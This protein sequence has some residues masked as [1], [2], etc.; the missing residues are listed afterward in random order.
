MPL[1]IPIVLCLS[2]FNIPDNFNCSELKF[3]EFFVVDV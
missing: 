2:S 1:I 3:S